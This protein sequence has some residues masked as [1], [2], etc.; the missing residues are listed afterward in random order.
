MKAKPFFLPAGQDKPKYIDNQFGGSLGGPIVKN[1]LFYFGSY[2]GSLNRQLGAT[3][4]TVPTAAVRA[5]DMSGSPNP[6]YDPLTGN[7][8]GTGR[9]EFPTRSF[10]PTASTLSPRKLLP[11]TRCRISRPCLRT[12]TTLPAPMYITGRSSMRRD[13]GGHSETKRCRTAWVAALHDEQSDRLRRFGRRARVNR[14]RSCRSA[15]GD[16][17]SS[18]YSASYVIRPT[19]VVDSYFGYTQ[20]NSNHDPVRQSEKLGQ[21]LGL[22]GTNLTDLAGGWP[23][24]DCQLR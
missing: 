22:P 9:T 23:L 8:D 21:M 24:P 19:L 17:Y 14:G 3:F 10:R 1:S 7:A 4:V 18:T 15:S 16:V 13:L 2:E 5:G 12:T 6:I 11:P 20:S